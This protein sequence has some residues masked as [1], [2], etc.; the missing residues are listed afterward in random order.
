[1]PILPSPPAHADG[2]ADR[3]GVTAWVRDHL[4]HLTLE[5]PDGVVASSI[6][7]G[8]AAADTALATLDVTGYAAR[9]S[10]VAPVEQRGASRMS[11][12]IRHGLVSLPQVWAAVADAPGRDRGKYRDELMWQ[13]YA[14]HVYARVGSRN[15]EPLR[16]DAPIARERWAGDPW[17]DRMACMALS[18]EELHGDGWLVNQVRMWLS[19]QWAVRAGADWREG[20]R[21]MYRHLL[22]GSAAANRLGWQWTIGAGTGKAY[23]FS[24]WQV[25]KRAPGLCGRCALRT[26]CPVQDWPDADAGPKVEPPPGLAGLD[27]G[28]APAA[29]PRAPEVTGEP[30][31]VW[32]TAESLGDNDPALVAHPDVPAVFVFDEPL[33]ARLRLSGKRLVF[34]TEALA[35]LGAQVRLGDPVDE[36]AGTALATTWNFTP[37]FARRS[38]AL[39]VVAL[40]PWPWLRRPGSGSLRSYSAWA[41]A[42]R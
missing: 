17:P 18:T 25:E 2:T 27:E 20:E 3:E 36:L 32:L 14:R 42:E 38:A 41:H 16:F 11:P 9:R 12:Y 34:L 1:M 39:D 7:G 33:L 37:G 21:E 6:P 23:G 30:E 8:Q 31:A 19:S 35:E 10:T 29:G 26:A 13:E 4:G 28:V 40:H 24:R 5:G 15:G 22:D